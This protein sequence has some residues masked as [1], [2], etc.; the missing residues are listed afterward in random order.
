MTILLKRENSMKLVKMIT[1]AATIALAQTALAFNAADPNMSGQTSVECNHRNPASRG[2]SF[3]AKKSQETQV[4]KKTE[5][6]K[7]HVRGGNG[8]K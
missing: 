2:T 7:A 1:I 6:P 4:V 3:F 5:T 8:V